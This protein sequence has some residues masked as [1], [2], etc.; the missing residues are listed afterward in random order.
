MPVVMIFRGRAAPTGYCGAGKQ[1]APAV[2]LPGLVSGNGKGIPF[3]FFHGLVGARP[4]VSD[5]NYSDYSFL[6][7]FNKFSNKSEFIF[8]LALLVEKYRNNNISCA[9]IGGRYL[10]YLTAWHVE[11]SCTRS[12]QALVSVTSVPLDGRSLLGNV[13][14]P[15]PAINTV[16]RHRG[17][18]AALF[19]KALVRE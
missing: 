5:Y 10:S 7:K 18:A 8:C 3:S 11:M 16:K 13:L 4:N 19:H 12:Y 17:H 1:K 2:P 9:R 6:K 15:F 14:I